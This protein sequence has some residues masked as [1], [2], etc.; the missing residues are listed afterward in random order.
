[1]N[2]KIENKLFILI[3][4]ILITNSF[5]QKIKNDDKFTNLNENKYYT[6]I[7][8]DEFINISFDQIIFGNIEHNSTIYYKIKIENDTEQIF[9]DFQSEFGCLYITI[10]EV[11][12]YNSSY[13]YMFCSEGIDNIFTLNRNEIFQKIKD[14]KISSISGLTFTIK[15]GLSNLELEQD[16]INSNFS[17]KVSARKPIINILEINSE[18]KTL[19]EMEKVHENNYRCLFI[20][21]HNENKENIDKDNMI[22]YSASQNKEI[23]L[24]IY[25]DYINKTLYDNYIIE[26]L[27]NKIPNINSTYN[28]NN[29]ELDFI[30]IPNLESNKYIYISV[31][32]NVKTTIEI[33]VQKIIPNEIK[34]PF[35]NNNIQINIIDKNIINIY[36]NSNNSI[37]ED[38]S[39]S[40]VTLQGKASIYLGYDN[41]TEYITDTIEN[42]LILNINKYSCNFN[43]SN[44]KLIIFNLEKN[45]KEGLDYIFYISY[46]AKSMNSLNELMYGKSNKMLF[47]DFQFPIL[48][49]EKIPNMNSPININFQIYNI[50]EI[51]LI[52]GEYDVEILVLQKKELH[53]IKLNHSYIKN[54]EVMKKK[55]DPFLSA[56]NIFISIKDLRFFG[57]FDDPFLVL[58]ITNNSNNKTDNALNK[59][60]LGSTISQ[61]NSLIYPSERIYHFGELNKEEKIV[62]KLKGKS[63]YHLMRLEFGSNSDLVEW[64]VKR[65]YDNDNYRENDTDL[66]FVTEKWINGRELLTMYIEHGEDIYLTIFT[67]NIIT[68]LNLTNY[69]F[70]YINSKKNDDFQNHL[71]KHNSLKYDINTRQID[72]N[73]INIIPP[74][75]KIVYYLKII[76]EK[77]YIKDERINTIAIMESNS[78]SLLKDNNDNNIFFNIENYIIRNNIYYINVYAVIIE[79]N[80][81]IEF[82]SFSEIVI[83]GRKIALKISKNGLIM[84]SFIIGCCSLLILLISL[85]KYCIYKNKRRRSYDDYDDDLFDDYLF[86]RNLIIDDI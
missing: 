15:V 24:N 81:N 86:N 55:F 76:N 69:I 2:Y 10:D 37:E 62:Y 60:I 54:F 44:C 85:I 45:D 51:S 3:L 12:L 23:K 32:S 20:F 79:K 34:L 57:I 19:C 16:N 17:L 63:E 28:N 83:E 18:H 64:T 72:I 71:I 6:N 5:S 48:L 70:K 9:F 52:Y 67:K 66:S 49:Y 31:E 47:T 38:F 42:K 53:R 26:D 61:I 82:I 46:K 13:D 59:L 78:T 1:M 30:N 77:D 33:V 8:N 35:N 25:I 40:L 43:E 29:T 68:N 50:P 73:K 39:L 22:I 21:T 74:N 84:S 58:Y 7:F 27:I 4:F 11:K 65:T 80:Y 75:S 14:N 36:F 41:S 56:V